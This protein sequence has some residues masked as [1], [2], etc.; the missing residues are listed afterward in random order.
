MD[1]PAPEGMCRWFLIRDFNVYWDK[2]MSRAV[3]S[4]SMCVYASP[5]LLMHQLFMLSDA[6]RFFFGRTVEVLMS[7]KCRGCSLTDHDARRCPIINEP[8]HP[9]VC[10]KATCATCST[11][12]LKCNHKGHAEYSVKA[13]IPDKGPPT[14]LCPKLDTKDLQAHVRDCMEEL[15]LTASQKNNQ[16]SSAK[17]LL[18]AI[19]SSG[20]STGNE[21]S[22]HGA[23]GE[24]VHRTG[25]DRVSSSPSTRTPETSAAAAMDKGASGA[26]ARVF[27]AYVSD[28][29][30]SAAAASVP[31]IPG[32]VA[33]G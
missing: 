19:R 5:F 14:F 22:T 29:T 12:C 15:P 33:D 13:P 3:V 21:L 20:A 17:R 25:L 16:R 8:V 32:V 28:A 1:A 4:A 27:G 23:Q 24:L 11:E 31:P 2:Q 26:A 18:A 9:C 7:R 30:H 10:K 6:N